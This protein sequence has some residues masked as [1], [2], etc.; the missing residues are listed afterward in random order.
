MENKLTDQTRAL[1]SR[2]VEGFTHLR[3]DK[4]SLLHAAVALVVVT[5]DTG[6]GAIVLTRRASHLKAH[7]GQWA[8]PGGRLDAGET[9]IEAALRETHEEVGLLLPESN[10]IGVLDD[11]PTRSGYLI[12]PVVVWGGNDVEMQASPDEVAS[13]HRISFSELQRPDS[14]VFIDIPESDKPVIRLLI[15][16][17]QVH[18]PTA[19]FMYQFTEVCLRNRQ[20]RVNHYEQPVFAWK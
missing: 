16:E 10:V 14:P 9:P 2:R 17:N 7:K 11:Y 15:G 3:Q 19:V 18:A 6:E 4:K 13:I 12:T 8:L 1:I 5:T 20:T